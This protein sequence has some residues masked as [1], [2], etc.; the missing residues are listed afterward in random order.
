MIYRKIFTPPRQ[1]ILD[2]FK[3]QNCKKDLLVRATVIMYN[4]LDLLGTTVAG[5]FSHPQRQIRTHNLCEPF[6]IPDTRESI[7]HDEH[8][9]LRQL[10]IQSP[11]TS[12][13]YHEK[14]YFTY[15]DPLSPL[16]PVKLPD[17]MVRKR[18]ESEKNTGVTCTCKKHS[19]KVN[20][21]KI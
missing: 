3:A 12:P 5:H 16:P 20:K 1:T 4:S 21:N 7:K 13:I 10:L 18:K 19:R 2:L 17:R 8:I 6:P 14:C 9:I 11:P 15:P